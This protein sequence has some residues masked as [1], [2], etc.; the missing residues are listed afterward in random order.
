[1]RVSEGE[2]REILAALFNA[3]RRRDFDGFVALLHDDIDWIIHG[4]IEVFSFAGLRRGRPCCRL[5]R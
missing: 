4:P 1:M 3:Y 2:T 5:W